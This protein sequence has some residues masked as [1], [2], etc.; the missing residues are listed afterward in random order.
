MIGQTEEALL[1]GSVSV[2]VRTSD[3]YLARK[4]D[5]IIENQKS[6]LLIPAT[7]NLTQKILKLIDLFL[8]ASRL[9]YLIFMDLRNTFTTAINTHRS[10]TSK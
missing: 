8:E 4:I 5:I 2:D 6:Q 3:L 10:K 7:D 9:I 1:N